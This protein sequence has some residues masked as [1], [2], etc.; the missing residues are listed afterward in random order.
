M[1]PY[2]LSITDA[3]RLISSGQLSPVELTRSALDRIEEVDDRL[4]AF[5]VVTAE[6]A[7][8][9]AAVAEKEIADCGYRGPLHGIPVGIKDL[10]DVAGLPTTAS[11]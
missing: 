5:V 1:N 9:A 3:A 7:L 4:H 11:S 10:Y 6:Q 2:Q 8:E